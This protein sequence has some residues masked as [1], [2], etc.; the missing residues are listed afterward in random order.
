MVPGWMA[1]LIIGREFAIAGLRS[2]AAAEGYVIKAS[3]LGKTKLVTQV[4]AVA[5]GILTMRESGA[6]PLHA[7][8]DVVRGVLCHRLGGACISASS[9]ARSMSR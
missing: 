1:I 5:L 7:L 4:I 8:L 9:G 6:S 2:I 3:D